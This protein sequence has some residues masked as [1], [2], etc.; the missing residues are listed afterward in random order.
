M[1]YFVFHQAPLPP[2]DFL[3][4]FNG[5]WQL[6][7]SDAIKLDDVLTFNEVVFWPMILYR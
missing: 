3:Q 6:I 5:R 4:E 2:L 7:P 1:E